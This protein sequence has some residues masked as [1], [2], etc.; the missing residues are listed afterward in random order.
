[1]PGRVLAVESDD[2][3]PLKAGD[4]G[5]APTPEVDAHF[6]IVLAGGEAQML[7][8][9]LNVSNIQGRHRSALADAGIP[10]PGQNRR[11]RGK[12]SIQIFQSSSFPVNDATHLGL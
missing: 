12:S 10:R 4:I 9:M 11:Q 2:A 3:V 1:M 5:I 6:Q 8:I 7:D